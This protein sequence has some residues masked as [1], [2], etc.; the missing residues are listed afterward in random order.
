MR[1][2]RVHEIADIMGG[3]IRKETDGLWQCKLW[4][5]IDCNDC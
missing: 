3:N 2:T 4:A 5:D 1:I